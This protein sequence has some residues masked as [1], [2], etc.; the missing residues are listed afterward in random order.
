VAICITGGSSGIG[1]AIAERFATEGNDVFVNFHANDGAAAETRSAIESR[2]ARCHLIKSDVGSPEGVR[3]LIE[4]VAGRVERLDQLVH[5]AAYAVPGSLLTVGWQELNASV[6]VNGLALVS[7][8]REALPLLESGSTVF[9]VTSRGAQAAIRDYGPLGVGKALGEHVVRHLAVEVAGRG[10]RV[11]SIS[12]GALDTAAFRS[13]FPESW[14]KVLA[15][16]A[17]A[18]PSGRALEFDDVAGMVEM[19]ARPE[20]SM[21]QGQTIT[22]DGGLSLGA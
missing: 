15:G 10:V 1:R 9:Y 7:L 8:V 3:T 5:A 21:V 14:E 18:N 4:R 11:N 22:V 19:L 16:A 12:P 20:F 2:G 6:A 17:R 13:M